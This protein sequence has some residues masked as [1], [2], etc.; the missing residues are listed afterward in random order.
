MKQKDIVIIIVVVI[1]S[2]IF[3][4]LISNVF[5]KSSINSQTAEVVQSINSSFDTPSSTYFNPNSINPTQIIKI[6][7]YNNPNPF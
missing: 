6:S 2:G 3:S 5:L 4:V 1:I 7:N